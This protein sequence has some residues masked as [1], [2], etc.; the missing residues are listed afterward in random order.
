[1]A[2]CLSKKSAWGAPGVAVHSFDIFFYINSFTFNFNNSCCQAQLQLVISIEIEL[3]SAESKYILD[4][5]FFQ[6]F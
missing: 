5:V 1:M 4:V 3:K 2:L 6:W